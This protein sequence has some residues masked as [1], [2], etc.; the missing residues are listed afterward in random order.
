MD[1]FSLL[2]KTFLTLE[3]F[4]HFTVE[5]HFLYDDNAI[6]QLKEIN[7]WR[8]WKK[9]IVTYW[10][11]GPKAVFIII[12]YMVLKK[13]S[14]YLLW[15]SSKF[16]QIICCYHLRPTLTDH[17]ATNFRFKL[18]GAFRFDSKKRFVTVGVV[19]ARLTLYRH[20]GCFLIVRK[21]AEKQSTAGACSLG[22]VIYSCLFGSF[23]RKKSQ[24]TDKFML[25]CKHF[26]FEKKYICFFTSGK[27]KRKNK[28]QTFKMLIV[29]NF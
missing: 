17:V 3:I 20:E 6:R 11:V 18:I 25:I 14:L 7:W 28:W 16:I 4:W 27:G 8:W 1:L 29:I 5:I 22:T 15:R 23:L 13:N 19:V 26:L 12:I 2:T 24:K 21:T 10:A 9:M